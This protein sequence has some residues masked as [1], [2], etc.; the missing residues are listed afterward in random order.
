MGI[1]TSLLRASSRRRGLNELLHLDDH[2]LND[3]G[4]TRSDVRDLIADRNRKA[5]RKHA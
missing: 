1:F 3:I 2:L 5:I 4:I